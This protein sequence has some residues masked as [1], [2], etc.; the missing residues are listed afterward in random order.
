MSLV[1]NERRVE[2]P[3]LDSICFLDDEKYQL[4]P[5]GFHDRPPD[6][7]I[8]AIVLHTRM[9]LVTKR[10]QTRGANRR[11]DELVAGR[12]DRS[13][14]MA[15]AHIAID[16]DGSFSCMC[17]LEL[18]AAH[19]AGHVNDFSIG[20][21]LYQGADG[22]MYL[23]TIEAA[24]QIVDVLTR[25]FGIQRQLPAE[26]GVLTRILKGGKKP[27]RKSRQL[28]WTPGGLA[29]RDFAGVY[30][31]RNTTRNRGRGDPGD[32]IMLE[33]AR[34]GYEIFELEQNEDKKRWQDRQLRYGAGPDGI[35]GPKTRAAFEAGGFIRGLWI[36]RPCDA[37]V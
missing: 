9:G 14:R 6:T 18:H 27:R 22:T 19:H 1:I 16:A 37:E 26:H 34:V 20:I 21:E 32:E 23:P 35:P 24:V 33:L 13:G 28:A 5:S 10:V 31:H 25:E 11:W 4:A 15:G 3:G 17:D 30:G 2:I 8:K 36:Y 29:G 12:W 7:W